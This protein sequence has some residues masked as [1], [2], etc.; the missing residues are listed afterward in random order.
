[1][2][3]RWAIIDRNGVETSIPEP[4]NGD[5]VS[6]S[7]TRN[8]TSHGI[9]TSI[10]TG[11]LAYYEDAYDLLK[12]EYD[13]HGADGRME[14]KIEYICDGTVYDFFRGKF[15][16]NT[17][18]RECGDLCVINCDVINQRCSDIF[19]TRLEQDVNI[20]AVFD[21]DG[22]AITPIVSDDVVLDGQDIPLTNLAVNDTGA[23]RLYNLIAI[24]TPGNPNYFYFPI[25]LPNLL[26]N[27]F[28][29]FAMNANPADVVFT[30]GNLVINFNNNQDYLD[31]SQFLNIWE[32]TSDP[33][34]CLDADA[35]INY[36]IKGKFRIKPFFNGTV[37]TALVLA[38]Y[39]FQTQTHTVID[40]QMIGAFRT[41]TNGVTNS[42][43]F[44]IIYSNTPAYK[45]ESESLMLYIA[46]VVDPAT[47]SGTTDPVDIGINYDP[48]TSFRMDLNSQ[49]DATETK[50]YRLDRVYEWLNKPYV[51][52]DCFD[53][54]V[55]ADTTTSCFDSYHLTNGLNIRRVNEPNPPQLFL[56]WN[57]L[58]KATRCMFNHGW[59]FTANETTL[60]VGDVETFYQGADV[61]NLGSIRNV[62]FTTAKDLIYGVIDIGYNK[63]E[64]EEYT[65]LDEMNTARQYRRN[66]QNSQVILDLMCDIIT[67][68]YTIEITRRKNQAKTGT[69]DWRYDNDLFLINTILQNGDYHAVR[70]V[71][72]GALNILSPATRM[73]YRLT[74]A[75]MMLNWFKSV[76]AARPTWQSETIDFSSGTGNYRAKG[77]MNGCSPESV[78][79]FEDQSFD[80]DDIVT[81]QAE[82]I[83]ETIIASFDAP[84][85][86][87]QYEALL[88]NPYGRVAFSCGATNYEGWIVTLELRPKDGLADVKLLIAR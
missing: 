28:N 47:S 18:K 64:A 19:M 3:Y 42:V 57:Q 68:G 40:L 72:S 1:M 6:V 4:V 26:L 31:Y 74:P 46:A 83:W 43:D 12:A 49:C 14:L 75:R 88:A 17:Y 29:D 77:K 80:K 30:F 70:G 7:F 84:M 8:M 33:L 76:S 39:D 21:M 51:G 15:D 85:T 34:N 82:P 22:N 71:D 36:R 62:Q 45:P 79:I 55:T 16:F 81:G 65:G 5:S 41:I 48:E 10:N 59:G 86:M 52:E 20:D 37:D 44:D 56:N 13:A 78:A 63:W 11:S 67:A 53:V 58:F 23:D 66:V 24:T 38:K 32:N 50:S 27:E 35:T 9:I 61:I 54:Q 73:N 2:I 60:L 69:S 25:Y 87:V